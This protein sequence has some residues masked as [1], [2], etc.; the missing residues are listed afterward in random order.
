MQMECRVLENPNISTQLL[1]WSFCNTYVLAL[2]YSFEYDYGPYLKKEMEVQS[3]M[4]TME[5][6]VV[7]QSPK[8][9]I[10]VRNCGQFLLGNR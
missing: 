8:T 1:S 10:V 3:K 5:A 9:R 4:Q 6:K 2:K 7:A